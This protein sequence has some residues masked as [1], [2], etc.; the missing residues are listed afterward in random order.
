MEFDGWP[1]PR[2]QEHLGQT[3]SL[4]TQPE[5]PHPPSGNATS[6][7]KTRGISGRFLHPH[8]DAS[9][10]MQIRVGRRHTRENPRTIHSRNGHP[11]SPAGAPI[12]GWYP[13][14]STSIR[15][16][17]GTWGEHQAHEAATRP[18][19][20]TSNINHWCGQ[21][22]QEPQAVWKLWRHSCPTQVPGIRY[23]VLPVPQKES[24]APGMPLG[25]QQHNQHRR[26]TGSACQSFN[27]ANEEAWMVTLPP[28]TSPPG[29]SHRH[30]RQRWWCCQRTGMPWI[31]VHRE[32][33][34]WQPWR[35]L[36]QSGHPVQAPGVPESKGRHRSTR[37]HSPAPYIPPNVPRKTG[38]K[39]ISSRGNYEEKTNHTA[40][41][42]RHHNKAA[43]C[44]HPLLQTQGHW[45]A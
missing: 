42:Q 14:S 21:Q 2:S 23:N 24:L 31:L 45:V 3:G 33:Q 13:H 17:K 20:H 40:G 29:N 15:H 18:N 4:R 39:R 35:T 6:K 11:K 10:E 5:L 28:R 12:K 19:T 27:E 37:K 30:R 41:V 25:Q 8:K 34:Q 9:A 22:Q 38:P 43:W 32:E 7:P 26:R 44:H 1:A 16:R 36:R